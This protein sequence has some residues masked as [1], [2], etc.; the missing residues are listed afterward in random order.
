MGAH[1]PLGLPG[2]LHRTFMVPGSDHYNRAR[3]WQWPGGTGPER[4]A[5]T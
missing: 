5:P 2:E 4:K 3:G 1:R